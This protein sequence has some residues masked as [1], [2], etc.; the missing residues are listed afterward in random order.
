MSLFDDDQLN[1]I[2]SIP[3]DY[4]YADAPAPRPSE[5]DVA[6]LVKAARTAS[7]VM[8]LD[9]GA[10]CR[11][12][13]GEGG[14]EDDGRGHKSMTPVSHKADCLYMKLNDALAKFEAHP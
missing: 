6:E 2:N 8:E 1:G 13:M 7:E 11:W 9:I 5:A 4:H 3:K 14:W 10:S 12:C